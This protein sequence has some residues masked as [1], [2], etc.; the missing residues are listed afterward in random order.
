MKKNQLTRRMFVKK[1]S[2]GTAG[3]ALTTGG[4]SSLSAVIMQDSG[5]PAILGGTPVRLPGSTIGPSWPIY[6]DTDIQM[7][8]DAYNSNIW[9]EYRNTEKERVVI[10]ENAFAELMGARYCAA[11]NS[12]TDAL[13]AAQR[14]LDI[15]PGDE[16]I[17][18]TNTFIATA[19]TVFN[20]FALPVLVDS[21]P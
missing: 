19:Q 20:L 15:G 14:A 9:S 7:Y 16:V 5:K 13:E 21:D 8:L 2:A 17:T 11:T 1:T 6:N 18:Q 10:F 3:I 12:G 4:V